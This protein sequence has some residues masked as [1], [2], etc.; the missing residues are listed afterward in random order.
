[1]KVGLTWWKH[2][3]DLDPNLY[4]ASAFLYLY[5]LL[6]QA[7]SFSLSASEH[8]SSSFQFHPKADSAI[9]IWGQGVYLGSDRRQLGEGLLLL[10]SRFSRV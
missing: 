9:R 4:M 2:R 3:S 7:L 10:L 8:L 1:M 6:L 5:F